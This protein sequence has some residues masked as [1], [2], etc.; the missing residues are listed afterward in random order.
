MA[1]GPLSRP[2]EQ[3]NMGF[4]AISLYLIYRMIEMGLEKCNFIDSQGRQ[5]RTKQKESTEAELPKQEQHCIA[6]IFAIC[7]LVN[8]Q[9]EHINQ[10]LRC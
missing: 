4:Q 5:I 10:A 2:R 8:S 7:C 9:L 3:G 1:E 6:V